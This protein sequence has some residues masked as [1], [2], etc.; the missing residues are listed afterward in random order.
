MIDGTYN[1]MQS[2]WFLVGTVLKYID[3]K[4]SINKNKLKISDVEKLDNELFKTR[5]SSLSMVILF[6]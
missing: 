1:M 3:N 5:N 2:I 4:N 6:E